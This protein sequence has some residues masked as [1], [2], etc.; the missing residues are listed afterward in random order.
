MA[1][2]TRENDVDH[3][4]AAG[5]SKRL[6]MIRMEDWTRRGLTFGRRVVE[7]TKGGDEPKREKKY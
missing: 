6:S 1:A 7:R 4:M 2:R 5:T 3:G